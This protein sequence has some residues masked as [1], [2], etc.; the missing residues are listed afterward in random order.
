[1]RKSFII[2]FLYTFS[3]LLLRGCVAGLYIRFRIYCWKWKPFSLYSFSRGI[4]VLIRIPFY[5]LWWSCLLFICLLLF[6]HPPHHIARIRSP[7]CWGLHTGTQKNDRNEHA[8][9]GLTFPSRKT[10][11]F[12]DN[13]EGK[14]RPITFFYYPRTREAFGNPLKLAVN[15]CESLQR[16]NW[17]DKILFQGL[18]RCQRQLSW[19]QSACHPA[20]LEYQN[21]SL[22]WA[23]VLVDVL[24]VV[25]WNSNPKDVENRR[26]KHHISS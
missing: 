12:G 24:F 23:G 4:Y 18:R 16:A 10:K 9:P 3:G 5:N 14:V 26:M 22:C 8:L 19:S 7:A 15:F 17:N 13:G 6:F 2:H 11:P 1:M 21:Q 25:E 20:G